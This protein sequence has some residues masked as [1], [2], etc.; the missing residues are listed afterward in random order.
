MEAAA[1]PGKGAWAAQGAGRC[2]VAAAVLLGPS[3]EEGAGGQSQDRRACPSSAEQALLNNRCKATLD[4][5]STLEDM[6]S[7]LY[8]QCNPSPGGSC[9]PGGSCRP[10]G[11]GKPRAFGS[12]RPAKPGGRRLLGGRPGPPGGP[13]GGAPRPGMPGKFGG[14]VG[15]PPV[16]TPG[17]GP[18]GTVCGAGA[19]GVGAAPGGRGKPR[20]AGSRAP[21][22]QLQ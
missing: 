18:P 9:N 22:K 3:Q 20:A 14:T 16:A 4:F 6:R 7:T 8:S 2:L 21:S 15:G 1:C 10:G 11:P 19:G 17:G 12:A 5:T 13:P